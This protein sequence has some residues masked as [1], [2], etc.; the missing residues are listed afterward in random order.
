MARSL[1]RTR[2]PPARGFAPRTRPANT[3]RWTGYV[4]F[5]YVLS[6]S[7]PAPLV[8]LLGDALA[9]LLPLT[10]PGM[11]RVMF[12]PVADDWTIYFDNSGL[13]T[14]AATV[15]PV[16]SQRLAVDA[17]LRCHDR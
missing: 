15:M 17:T 12:W 9:G 11:L 7:G 8:G 16:L 3:R 2:W 4:P 5:A 1:P 6:F 13:G 14:E 10:M